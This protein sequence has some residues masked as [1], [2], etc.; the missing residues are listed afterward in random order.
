MKVCG[1]GGEVYGGGC[2]PSRVMPG[3]RGTP[4][5]IR[6]ISAFSRHLDR[7]LDSGV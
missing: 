1:G 4:A 7:P 5:G 3:F 6:T 2:I